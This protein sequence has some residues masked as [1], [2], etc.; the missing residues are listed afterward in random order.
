MFF[1]A[2]LSASGRMSCASCHDPAHAYGPPDGAAVRM[3]GA[4]MDRPGTRAV[5]SLRYKTFTPMFQEHFYRQRGEDMEDEGPTGGFTSDGRV[6]TAAAQARIPLLDANEMA[7]G[8]AQDFVHRLASV[9]YVDEFKAAFGADALADA[10][11]AL[12]FAGEAL[13]KF[14]EEDPSF[15]PYTSKYDRYLHGE[16]KLSE[17]ELRGLLLFNRKDK[18][19]CAQ[20]HPS[21]PGANRRPPQF[22][23][24]GFDALGVP[25]NRDIAANADPQYF[26]L[27]LC[28]P[29]RHD[30]ATRKDFCGMCFFTT[31]PSTRSPTRCAFMSRAT[32]IRRTGI[33][34]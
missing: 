13:Q 25:R 27:G 33:P 19:N 14:Q 28:G 9:P 1:D 22:T 32:P 21:W 26:D 20:C 30:L 4:A 8:N 5:P 15:S 29:A 24:F 18:G 34:R 2:H 11:K 16:I 12:G 17:A 23:D 10:E 6:N 31:A 7:N 3:G